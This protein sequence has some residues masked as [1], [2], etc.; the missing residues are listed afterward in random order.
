MLLLTSNYRC[1]SCQETTGLS[2]ALYGN[3]WM[4]SN[5]AAEA[6]SNITIKS[7][8]LNI[9]EEYIPYMKSILHYPEKY[10]SEIKLILY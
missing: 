5:T 7:C 2:I 10:S 9:Y 8:S 1:S 3:A 4:C 6:H